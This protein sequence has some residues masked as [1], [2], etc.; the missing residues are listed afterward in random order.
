MQ[1]LTVTIRI[2]PVQPDILRHLGKEYIRV[3]NLLTE[4]AEQLR[5]F[6]K[7]TTKN[8][9]TILPSA[10]CNQSIRDAKSV[11]RKSKKLG[12]RPILKK[13]V[14]FVNNQN[15]T[16]KT[17]F[18]GKGR[19]NK[20]IRRK[21]Q[22]RRRQLGKLKKLSAIRKLGNKEQRWMKDQN[23]KISRQIVNTAIQEGVSIIKL[24]RLEN[25]RKTARTSRKNAK[26][27]HN[28]TFY[29]LQQCISYKVNLAGIQ[30]VEV[31]PAYTSQSCPACR[32]KNKAKDRM[33]E[34]SCGFHAHRDRVGA[35]NIMR[36]PVAD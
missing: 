20:Y 17:C 18:F 14:Y 4:Q 9:E 28:W 16:G 24:E 21:H 33:Y 30:V 11:F 5:S 25:I 8:V 12:G 15:S 26:N 29:Q 35:I 6:P 22:Q 3:V 36:Q 32:E 2:F 27:L 13:P 23:H 34:C 1:V 19:Q 10:V 31:N 7:T